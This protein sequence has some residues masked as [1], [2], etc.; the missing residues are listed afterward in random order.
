MGPK[1]AVCAEVAPLLKMVMMIIIPYMYLC[2]I[3]YKVLLE[4]THFPVSKLPM[5]S[6]TII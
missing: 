6:T 5:Y 3:A 1:N 4:T 2:A